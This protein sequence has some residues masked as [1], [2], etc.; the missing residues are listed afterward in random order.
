MQI[1]DTELISVI[2]CTYNLR[3]S[4]LDLLEALKNQTYKNFELVLID[5]GPYPENREH[6]KKCIR[7]YSFKILVASK[8]TGLGPGA[9]RNFGVN[10]ANANYI[11]FTDDDCIP[12]D[13]WLE[14]IYRHLGADG[15]KAVTGNVYS[16]APPLFP[17]IHSFNAGDAGIFLSGNS[18]F[19]KEFFIEIGGF[20]EFLNN[21]AED[22]DIGEKTKLSGNA[23]KYV[24]EMKV[25]H[26][27][28]IKKY[29]F[30]DNLMTFDFQKKY[31]YI[32]KFKKHDYKDTILLK[33]FKRAFLKILFFAF[34]FILPLGF[35]AK[36]VQPFIFMTCFYY[37]RMNKRLAQAKLGHMVPKKQ[38]FY[39]ASTSWM[40]DIINLFMIFAFYAATL[41]N[42]KIYK[43]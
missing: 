23:F 17:F 22:F 9:G 25:N 30:K 18:A 21:W 16:A 4:L 11:A 27:P 10:H 15:E 37:L 31:Y 6:I 34:F 33:T 1:N 42:P 32:L 35:F 5:N 36:I 8:N 2:V 28:F 14:T 29:C 39:Y 13:N 43:P 20:D 26:P 40:K 12:D 19:H 24:K 3:P 7:D 41:I 38:I